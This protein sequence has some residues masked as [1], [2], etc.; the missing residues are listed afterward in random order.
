MSGLQRSNL[1]ALIR[2]CCLF[3]FALGLAPWSRADVT[4]FE[5]FAFFTNGALPPNMTIDIPS[6]FLAAE[7][8]A[9]VGFC[10][11]T[12]T[13]D[14]SGT[15]VAGTFSGQFVE[16]FTGS[17]A[18]FLAFGSGGNYDVFCGGDPGFC[19][20]PGSSYGFVGGP[21]CGSCPTPNICGT[22]AISER[23]FIPDGTDIFGLGIWMNPTPT[24]EP[25]SVILLGTGLFGILGAARRK[26]LG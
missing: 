2:A 7:P 21:T 24:P 8:S 10:D 6:C 18:E 26:L 12:V 19:C 1:D 25:T 11:G 17:G 15:I 5:N 13:T 9:L 23:G 4:V 16:T 14:G 20:I 22:P 3:A